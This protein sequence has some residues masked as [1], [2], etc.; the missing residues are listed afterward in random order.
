MT[1]TPI[2]LSGRYDPIARHLHWAMALLIVGAFILGLTVDAF[3]ASWKR[4]AIE[5][6]KA[7]GLLLIVLLMLRCAWRLRHRPPEPEESS[8]LLAAIAR[9]GHAGLYALMLIVPAIGL[10]YAIRRGQ[11]LD[12]GLFSIPPLAAP[13]PRADTRPIREWHEWASY[14]LIALAT[15]HALAA[16]WHHLV[17]KDDTLRRMLPPR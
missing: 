5:S 16:L 15:L 10:V 1:S 4:A 9:V 12:L 17:R 11:G 8:P 14:A 13:A 3:P 2:A 6:H 7:I